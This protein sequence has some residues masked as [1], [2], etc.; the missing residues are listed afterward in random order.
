[1]KNIIKIIKRKKQGIDCTE[2]ESAEIK[3]WLRQL[4]IS[5]SK[6]QMLYDIQEYFSLE[7]GEYLDE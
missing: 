1:M 6:Q 3:G 4:N 2:T 5:K 7:Y